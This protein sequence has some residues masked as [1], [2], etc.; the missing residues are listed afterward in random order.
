MKKLTT[1]EFIKKA[2]LIHNNKYDY[3]KT[4]YTGS[5]NSIIITCFI[6]GDFTTRASRHL[7]GCGCPTCGKSKGGKAHKNLTNAFKKRETEFIKKAKLL[8]PNYDYSKVIYAGENNN[9]III[10]PVHGEFKQTPHNHI[11]SRTKC[12]L[13]S[14]VGFSKQEKEIVDYI[15]RYYNGI[16]EENNRT[17]LE[18]K[19]LD[20]YLPE[21]KLAIEYDGIYWHNS[22]DNSYKFEECK[23]KG[24]RLIQITE[25]DWLNKK[26][27]IKDL[28]SPHTKIYARNCIIK[29]ELNLDFLKEN[30][31]YDYIPTKMIGLYYNNELVYCI[32]LNENIMYE[33]SKLNYTIIGGKSKLLKYIERNYN[34]NKLIAI[35]DKSKFSGESYIKCGFTLKE[36]L[37]P[38]ITVFKNKKKSIDGNFK[39][40]DY[41]KYVYEKILYL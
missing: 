27:F 21:L 1:E 15:K 41:G 39:I 13:C 26:S 40:F 6:H 12:P 33:C 5:N 22:I 11:S 3:S 25:W 24:I 2:K 38:S 32:C 17:I 36:E 4:I 9:V 37:P 14:N 23:K 28:V 7:N 8:N 30:Y 29:E 20:I 19:E 16:I 35:C 34:L 18:G 10:C 31:L